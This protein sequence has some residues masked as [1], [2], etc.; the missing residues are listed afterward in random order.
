VAETDPTIYAHRM[1]AWAIGSGMSSPLF[2]EVR[3]KRGLV[4][5]VN[6]SHDSGP[7]YGQ[8][9]LYAGTTPDKLDEDFQSSMP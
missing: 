2:Q 7:D 3:E 9:M 6:G 4:Y 5:T 8:F 1:L